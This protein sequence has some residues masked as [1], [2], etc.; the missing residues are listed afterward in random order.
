MVVSLNSRL[1]NNKEEKKKKGRYMQSLT[2][3]FGHSRMVN[4]DA[5]G[6]QHG[7]PPQDVPQH[8]ILPMVHTLFYARVLVLYGVGH[9]AL[10]DACG[11]AFRRRMFRSNSS[12]V[13][14]CDCLREPTGLERDL[15]AWCVSFLVKLVHPA[16]VSARQHHAGPFVP[17]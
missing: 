11:T 8:L 12:C 5:A 13:Q 6:Q 1:E 2:D 7:F 16:F 10:H 3:D 4:L 17:Q 9:A 15:S 14:P